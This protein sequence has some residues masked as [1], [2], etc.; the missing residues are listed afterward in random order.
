MQWKWCVPIL[1]SLSLLAGDLEKARDAQDRAALEK[2][3]AQAAAAASQAAKDPG[4]QQQAALS[5]AYLA[6][7]A[8]EAGDKPRAK[9]AA[10]SGMAFARNAV[11]LAPQSAEAH[12][13]LGTLCGQVIPANVLA[14]L[15]Y[16]TCAKEEVEKAVQ[17]DPKGALNFVSRGVGYYDL[18]PA[19]GGGI[20]KAIADFE[21]AA[22]LDPK[23]DE[24]HLW[25]GIAL[26]KAGRTAD[27]RKALEK[28]AQLNTA[29]V[30]TRQQLAKTP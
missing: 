4:K 20:D 21:K 1:F 6:E 28:A 16:G 27:A 2:L 22:A 25:L 18:P 8:T 12:R 19:F 29:R 30:W 9:A 23:L 15:K 17:L 26:R 5:F 13:L 14:G 10:E 3:S 11:A 7:I 24:A